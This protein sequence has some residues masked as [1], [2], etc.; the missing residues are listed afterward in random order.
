MIQQYGM[1]LSIN[2]KGNSYNNAVMKS[3]FPSLQTKY[4]NFCKF[5]TKEEAID[6]IFT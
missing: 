6:R 4:A 2:D 5:T 1:I 3:F